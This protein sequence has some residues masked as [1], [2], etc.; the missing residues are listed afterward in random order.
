MRGRKTAAYRSPLR[1]YLTRSWF[2]APVLALLLA[3]CGLRPET[4]AA[5]PAS[6]SPVV[7]PRFSAEQVAQGKAIYRANCAA[8]HGPNGEGQPNWKLPRD[9]GTYP[10]PPHT[11]DGHTWHHGDGTLF[12][13]IKGGG[14]SLEIPN[15]KSG[16][17]AF[18]DQLN[19][20]EIILVLTYLKSLWPEEL[21]LLQAEASLR[22]P[23]PLSP[24]R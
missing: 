24:P 15:F 22:D 14:A 17:P 1:R 23:F 2:I 9:D 19:D 4:A 10:A 18:G 6:T 13:I 3:G 11:A 21:R 12:Q 8:C 20:R 16:M 5:V 7:L